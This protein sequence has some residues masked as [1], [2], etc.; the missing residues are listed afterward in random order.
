MG[1]GQAVFGVVRE[2]GSR[3]RAWAGQGRKELGR[4]RENSADL[5]LK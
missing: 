2:K 3:R 1:V 5:D 4:A